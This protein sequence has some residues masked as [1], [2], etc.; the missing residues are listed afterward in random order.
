M[1]RYAQHVIKM[2]LI[3]ADHTVIPFCSILR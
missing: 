3:S 2:F 1:K